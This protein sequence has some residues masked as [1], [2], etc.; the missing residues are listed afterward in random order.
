MPSATTAAQ[1]DGFKYW[2]FISYSHRDKKWGDW[3]HRSLENYRVPRR[4][5]GQPNRD[6]TR[7][8]RLFPVFRDLEELPASGDL[9][10]RVN[11][12]L[13]VSR[14]LVVVC[15]PEAAKSLLVNEEIQFFKKLGFSATC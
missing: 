14:Y 1:S 11:E 8:A 2:A 7:P 15:S 6:G 3:L 12:A 4:L 13:T 10:G 9:S 5:V